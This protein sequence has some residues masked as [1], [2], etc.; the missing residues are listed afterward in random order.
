MGTLKVSPLISKLR[1]LSA[2]PAKGSLAQVSLR[3][4]RAGRRQKTGHHEPCVPWCHI[5]AVISLS[6]QSKI[7]EMEFVPSLEYFRAMRCAQDQVN[8]KN[9]LA[10]DDREGRKPF[11][12]L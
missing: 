11:L 12:G 2:Q 5:L 3:S 10:W 4:C 6:G 8:P 1:T 9:S 7:L